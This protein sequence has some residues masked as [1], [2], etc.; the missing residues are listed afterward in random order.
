VSEPT[1]EIRRAVEMPDEN[2]AL[3]YEQAADRLS[4]PPDRAVALLPLRLGLRAAEVC[5]LTREAVQKAIKTGQLK[6]TV[7]GGR[8]RFI[9]SGKVTDLLQVLLDTPKKGAPFRI[10][11]KARAKVSRWETVGE[12]FSNGQG[13]AQYRALWRVVVLVGKRAG[14]AKSRP[15]LL[16]HAFGTRMNRDGASLSTIQAALGHASVQTTQRYVH[17]SSADVAKYMR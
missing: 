1:Y 16:R 17:P 2:D 4:W 7:K 12:I 11:E 13:N 5:S 15:H 10:E 3:A 9:P 6:A 8:E 14:W